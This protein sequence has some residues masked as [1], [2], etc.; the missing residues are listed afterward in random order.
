MQMIELKYY[1]DLLPRCNIL[2][3]NGMVEMYFHDVE[4][5]A[6]YVAREFSNYADESYIVENAF[7][8]DNTINHVVR[9]QKSRLEDIAFMQHIFTKTNGQI[10]GYAIKKIPML[11]FYLGLDVVNLD[12]PYS[13]DKYLTEEKKLYHRNLLKQLYQWFGEEVNYCFIPSKTP[14]MT[15]IS[16]TQSNAVEEFLNANYL[17]YKMRY[18]KPEYNKLKKIDADL[19]IKT[20]QK[21]NQ[22]FYE[23]LSHFKKKYNDIYHSLVE[24]GIV[25]PKWKSEYEMFKLIKRFFNDA[26]Y[27]YKA[28]WLGNQSLDV[29][30]PSKR[31][32]IE[33]QGEQHY[34]LI[35]HFGG[36]ESFEKRKELDR[37]KKEL[38]TKNDVML[39]EWKYSEPINEM[40]LKNKIK[41][42]DNFVATNYNKSVA[43]KMVR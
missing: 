28:K 30:I 7:S 32:G 41:H 17:P 1:I 20:R 10:A 21:D 33:Y 39:I 27:Q 36:K 38:C 13:L 9:F 16:S 24:K 5:K 14:Y 23:M 6:Y 25:T 11:D 37:Q 4:T 34:R 35:E 8:D 31:I 18:E 19:I 40:I 12:R 29:Y 42:L 2:T 43:T 3:D 15:K 22:K 26:V